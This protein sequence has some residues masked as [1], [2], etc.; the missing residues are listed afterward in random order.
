MRLGEKT[1]GSPSP[2]GPHRPGRAAPLR[3]ILGPRQQQARWP[4][5]TGVIATFDR[6]GGQVWP[7]DS[8]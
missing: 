3:G 7:R 4:L 5:L 1:W 8:W 6:F 2:H